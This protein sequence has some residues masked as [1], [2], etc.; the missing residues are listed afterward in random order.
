MTT[1][2]TLS[3]TILGVA[4]TSACSTYQ[5]YRGARAPRP[6]PSSTSS[7]RMQGPV[8]AGLSAGGFAEAR[9]P[10]QGEDDSGLHLPRAQGRMEL[11]YE[12]YPGLSVGVLHERGLEAGSHAID[13]GTPEPEGDTHGYGVSL[14]FSG[15]PNE[16]PWRMGMVV[17]FMV[18]A[19]P[20]IEYRVCVENCTGEFTELDE[21]VS[22]EPVVAA[23]L[24]TS[25][26]F[27]DRLA[28][29]GGLTLRNHPTIERTG[30]E[31]EIT[32]SDNVESGPLNATLAVG[33]EYTHESGV[34]A[35]L[36]AYQTL[37]NNPV[38]YYPALAASV[39]IPLVRE[40]PRPRRAAPPP[41]AMPP[42]PPL[43]GQDW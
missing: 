20:Y 37:P 1:K 4:F 24:L 22:T 3:I 18:F 14:G 41:A 6:L 39:T 7:Q 29:T 33:L 8:E 42:P 38:T 21:G 2:T 19:V 28:V 25:Y 5:V 26:A 43:P 11:K 13:K 9:L 34:R 40:R 32:V 27:S 15:Q 16:S 10:E 12:A 36:Q 30:I 23:H 31:G 35:A 17:D